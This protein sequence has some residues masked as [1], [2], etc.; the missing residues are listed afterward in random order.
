MPLSP[1]FKLANTTQVI[2]AVGFGCWK[3]S[4]EL[5]PSIV[6]NAIEKGYRHIDSAADYGKNCLRPLTYL[7]N[8]VWD[9]LNSTLQ[10]LTV[11]IKLNIL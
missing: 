4:K 1:T 10:V 3:V 7:S 11:M 8:E 6:E 9:F 2:P 5:A